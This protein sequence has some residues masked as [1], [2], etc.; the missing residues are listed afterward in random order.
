MPLSRWL[1]GLLGTAGGVV[2]LLSVGRTSGSGRLAAGIFVGQVL[3][4]GA[5]ALAP[6]AAWHPFALCLL[7]TPVG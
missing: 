3:V 6:R 4:I 7:W 2:L 1:I 5:T